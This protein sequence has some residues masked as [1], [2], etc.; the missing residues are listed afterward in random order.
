MSMPGGY[1]RRGRREQMSPGVR[2][3][4]LRAIEEV[5]EE[6]KGKPQGPGSSLLSRCTIED[7]IV[8]A[9]E[10]LRS[11]NPGTDRRVPSVST[12]YRLLKE[13]DQYD[14]SVATKGT[15]LANTE[16]R[17]RGRFPRQLDYPLQWCQFDETRCPIFLYHK[18]IGIPLV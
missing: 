12:Y 18:R 5:V 4:C 16:N 6:Y 14:L 15:V 9:V 10:K 8:A 13:V 3:A 1:E 17:A 7:R 2:E 11:E